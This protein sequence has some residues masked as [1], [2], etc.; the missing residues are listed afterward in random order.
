MAKL[1]NFSKIPTG[2]TSQSGGRLRVWLRKMNIT[3][4]EQLSN[5]KASELLGYKNFGKEILHELVKYLEVWFRQT[6]FDAYSCYKKE[7]EAYK[8]ANNL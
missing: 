6:Y 3:T 5:M 7:H 1:I 8:K 4:N 2:T